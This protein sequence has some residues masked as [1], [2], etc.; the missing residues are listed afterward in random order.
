MVM[1]PGRVRVAVSLATAR[2]GASVPPTSR[3]TSPPKVCELMTLPAETPPTV[4]AE[5]ASPEAST[6]VVAPRTVVEPASVFVPE[7]VSVP[8]PWR[9]K[10]SLFSLVPAPPNPPA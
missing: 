3:V 7:R 9:M 1:P 4:S 5:L 8:P 6:S 10:L 2:P